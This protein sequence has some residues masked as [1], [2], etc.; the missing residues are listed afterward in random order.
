[1]LGLQPRPVTI[2]AIVYLVYALPMALYVLWPQRIR[3]G[4]RLRRPKAKT[5]PAQSPA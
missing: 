2:E 1:M 3:P 4:Q 5:A